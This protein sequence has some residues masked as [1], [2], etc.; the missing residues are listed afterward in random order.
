MD[1]RAL[2]I[3][4]RLSQEDVA[5]KV[6]ITRPAYTHIEGRKR[7]PSPEVAKKIAEALGFSKSWYKLLDYKPEKDG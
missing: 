7:R 6:G 5:E 4:K 1:L 3:K 2:R